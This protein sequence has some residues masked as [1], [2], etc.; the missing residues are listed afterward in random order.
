M[1]SEPILETKDKEP[2][3]FVSIK[4]SEEG[5]QQKFVDFEDANDNY[6]VYGCPMSECNQH[7]GMI[8]KAVQHFQIGGDI[9]E[10]AGGFMMQK[11]GR[12]LLTGS[13]INLN[14][15]FNHEKSK[16]ALEK[17]FPGKEVAIV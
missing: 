14:K 17:A 9:K 15:H 13:S 3:S 2:E 10:K 8:E 5:K 6:Y 4:W 11:E 1:E 16:A 12:I 7:T